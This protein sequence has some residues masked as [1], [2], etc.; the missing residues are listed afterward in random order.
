VMCGVEERFAIR[1]DQEPVMLG[2]TPQE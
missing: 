2:F 1:L